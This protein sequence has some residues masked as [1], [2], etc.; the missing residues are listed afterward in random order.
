MANVWILMYNAEE[1]HID[2][3]G[4]TTYTESNPIRV[5]QQR[6]TAFAKMEQA[7]AEAGPYQSDG[8]HHYYSLEEVAYV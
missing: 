7:N 3:E 1:V 2:E 4:E 6:A 8:T 5:Y